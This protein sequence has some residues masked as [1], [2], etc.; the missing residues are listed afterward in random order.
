MTS[1]AGITAAGILVTYPLRPT[2]RRAL[3]RDA[4]SRDWVPFLVVMN[5]GV[6]AAFS[7]A[8]TALARFSCS[9][10]VLPSRTARLREYAHTARQDRVCTAGSHTGSARLFTSLSSRAAVVATRG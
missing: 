9:V 7:P 5:R 3:A 4:S 10:R 1:P 6:R 2:R 8:I